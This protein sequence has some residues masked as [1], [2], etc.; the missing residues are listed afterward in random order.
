LLSLHGI[1]P[2]IP[3]PFDQ[4]GSFDI[5]RLDDNLSRWNAW[6]LDGYV[7][8]GSTGEA[9]ALSADE[10]VELVRAARERVP[11]GKLLIAGA[12]LE[13][14]R[15]TIE[16][17]RRMEAAR[18]DAAI[19]VT[20]GY[21][22]NSLTPSGL[23]A[24]YR[25]IADSSPLPIVLYSVPVYTHLDLSVPVVEIL[26]THANIIGIKES[27][28][29]LSKIA[30]LVA[31]TPPEF[32]VV[33]GS[34]GLLLGALVVGAVGCVPALGCVAGPQIRELVRAFQAGELTRARELQAALVEANDL[35]TGRFGVP[36]VKAAMDLIGFYG[37]PPRS[38]LQPLGEAD[39]VT[40]RQGLE[41]AGLL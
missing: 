36:G 25:A 18:A 15:G 10:R 11:E 31:R 28:G 32:Q 24:H 5:A 3:T 7:V 35:L 2:P 9:V 21:F 27:G 1:Y 6:P 40:L 13:S 38:P 39:L 23:V 17:V 26:S 12:G 8:C 34:A 29:S 4:A 14:T 22:A 16:L 41:R 33:V 19:V 30:S 20:P 37:G